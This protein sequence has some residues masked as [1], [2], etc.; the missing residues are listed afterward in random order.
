MHITSFAADGFRNLHGVRLEPDPQSNL[1]I[2]DNAQGKTNLL[3]A[4]WLMTG[5]RSFHGAKERHYL[6]FDADF[7]QC[8]M[9]FD[10][11]QRIQRIA[12]SVERGQP[13]RRKIAIN[14]VDT[15]KTGGLFEA[16]HCVA[17][18]PSDVELVSGGPEKRRSFMDLCACQLRPVGMQYVSR[19]AQIL[20]Q[21]N[22]GIAGAA[23]GRLKKRDAAMWDDQLALTGTY[24]SCLRAA[25]VRSLAPL[26][27]ELYSTMTGG[28]EVLDIAYRSSV[29][30]TEP[31]P[32]K[33][34]PE[35]VARYREMLA[36]QLDEDLRLGYTGRGIQRDDLI[37]QI[38]GN[39]VSIFGSQGQRKSTALVLK[40]AQAKLYNEKN[41]R[42]PVV[43][44]DDVM[45][46]LDERRQRLIYDMVAQMQVF[47]TLCH[48]SSLRIER[49]G[50]TF[51]MQAGVLTE[52][53]GDAS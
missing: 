16:F 4:I 24:I 25:F 2:G 42:S 48:P 8:D 5:C 41:G 45:G 17:F 39:A 22:A 32:E 52:V 36:Q 10:D 14:G 15:Q 31:L 38:D 44:L 19:A 49:R 9:Q 28:S 13:R 7:F 37:L 50:K 34:T 30:G 29:F 21:R 18:S 27:R 40:L 35:L 6:G 51:R 3:D 46:E 20:A 26:C 1:I 43:L 53:E 33:P 12:Y 47:I 11:G 23:R